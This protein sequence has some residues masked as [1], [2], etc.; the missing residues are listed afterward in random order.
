M[1]KWKEEFHMDQAHFVL[2]DTTVKT[3]SICDR[4]HT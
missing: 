2:C 1:G 4:D 3:M